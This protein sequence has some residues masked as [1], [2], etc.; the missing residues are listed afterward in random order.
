ME[1][2]IGSVVSA[3]NVGG[4]PSDGGRAPLDQT[5]IVQ[6][7]ADLLAAVDAAAL[8][9]RVTRST[10]VRR[11]LIVAVEGDDGA[12]GPPRRGIRMPQRPSGLRLDHRLAVI[13]DRDFLG[14]LDAILHRRGETRAMFIERALM[15]A[16]DWS[17]PQ[18]AKVTAA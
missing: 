15:K 2:Q 11:I 4:R 13:V 18:N 16:L 17:D 7:T 12:V 8:R 5:L 1:A 9:E 10:F 6:V 14:W 3:P